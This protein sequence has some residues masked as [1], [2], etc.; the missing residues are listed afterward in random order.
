ML[1]EAILRVSEIQ[2]GHFSIASHFGN[3]R[4]RTDFRDPAIPFTTAMEGTGNA[5]QRL[6]SIRTYSGAIFS[7]ATA[8]CIAS[9]VACRMFS[10]SI[11]CG[12]ARP[13][14]R[15]M[16]F[17]ESHQITPVGAFL[18]AFGVI[19]PDNRTGRIEDHRRG[20][21]SATNGPRPL[22]PHPQQGGCED[23]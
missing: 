19:Q 7:P 15:L 3:N 11:S 14:L 6:P 12:S 5:G 18:K 21:N 16:L 17:P 4:S 9:I 23:K 8:R 1:S 13:R 22:R 10:S 20:H 2:R